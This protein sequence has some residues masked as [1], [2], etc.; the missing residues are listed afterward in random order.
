MCFM[1]IIVEDDGKREER[2]KV[3]NEM[4]EDMFA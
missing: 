1:C 3:C 2:R 4:N